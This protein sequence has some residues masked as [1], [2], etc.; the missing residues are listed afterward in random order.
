MPFAFGFFPFK[1]ILRSLAV[2]TAFA[3]MFAVKSLALVIQES[4]QPV[5]RVVALLR[6]HD[7]DPWYSAVFFSDLVHDDGFLFPSQHID[8]KIRIL[9]LEFINLGNPGFIVCFPL[10]AGNRAARIDHL[11]IRHYLS[12]F[13]L[14]KMFLFCSFLAVACS[15]GM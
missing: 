14:L 12:L 10:G 2:Q 1:Q 4:C 9:L 6:Y 5:E 11:I 13:C 3:E 7:I 15:S 8:C